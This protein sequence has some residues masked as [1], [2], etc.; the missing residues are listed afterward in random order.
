M[1]SS[2]EEKEETMRKRTLADLRRADDDDLS[3]YP[4]VVSD[5]QCWGQG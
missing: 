2:M 1:L 5:L 3:S 4:D